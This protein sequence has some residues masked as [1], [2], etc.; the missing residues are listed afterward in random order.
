MTSQGHV[1][2][3]SLKQANK[4]DNREVFFICLHL[5]KCCASILENSHKLTCFTMHATKLFSS[6]VNQLDPL[7]VYPGREEDTNHCNQASDSEGDEVE[8]V[9][10]DE[11]SNKSS[12]RRSN[13]NNNNDNTSDNDNNNHN[14]NLDS[15]CTAINQSS[16]AQPL[17]DYNLPPGDQCQHSPMQGSSQC[18]CKCMCNTDNVEAACTNPTTSNSRRGYCNSSG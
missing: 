12:S 8:F 6:V 17:S 1:T 2:T 3:S 4:E 14:N 7:L 10:S 15:R 5:E 9:P 11:S 13:K 18:R 16:R